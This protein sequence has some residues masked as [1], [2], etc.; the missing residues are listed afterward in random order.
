MGRSADSNKGDGVNNHSASCTPTL[1]CNQAAGYADSPL[2]SECLLGYT[3]DWHKG[4]CTRSNGPDFGRLAQYALGLLIFILYLYLPIGTSSGQSSMAVLTIALNFSQFV[5]KIRHNSHIYE[6]AQALLTEQYGAPMAAAT[7]LHFL[8][9]YAFIL[10][11]RL[12][13]CWWP[14]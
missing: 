13:R 9:Q 10:L 6:W 11:L 3:K 8:P 12:M 14:R 2:C 4:T 1:G 5:S 7:G